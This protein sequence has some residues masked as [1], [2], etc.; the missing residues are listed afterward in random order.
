VK[1]SRL[2]SLVLLLQARGR[3][4]AA[5][6]ARELEVSVRTIYRDVDALSSAGVPVYA[7]R[8][9]G[10]GVSLLDGWSADLSLL[11]TG[12]ATALA[13]GVPAAAAELGLGA[14]LAA[15]QVK[16]RSSLPPALRDAAEATAARFHLDAPRW[17]SRPSAPPVLTTVAAAAWD[18]VRLAFDY[19]RGDA[20]VHRVVEPL[21]LVLKAGV[22]YLVGRIDDRERVYR[23]S[24]MTTATA[25]GER[26]DR[27]DAF[28]LPR[29]WQ[30][31]QESFESGFPELQAVVRAAPTVGP[32]PWH[33]A[34]HRGEGEPVPDGDDGWTRRTVWYERV[35]WAAV[36]LLRLGPVVEVLEPPELREAVARAARAVADLYAG[37]SQRTTSL[38]SPLS[39]S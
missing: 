24:R 7:E 13:V 12:E 30:A 26:F 28:D 36:E 33:V 22:W 21:G 31:H 19:R 2:L 14:V 25:T 27:P 11:T 17:F 39:T 4:T 15:A 32:E 38:S 37:R 1:A 6:L 20:V 29:F 16:V 18:D 8:G 34:A 23:L 10:G 3:T 5:A 9:P 35:D